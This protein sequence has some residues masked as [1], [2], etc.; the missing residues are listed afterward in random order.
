MARRN[1]ELSD[2]QPACSQQLD[3]LARNVSSTA[4][5][6]TMMRSFNARSDKDVYICD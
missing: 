2:R 3:G 6:E 5:E 1:D 4:S